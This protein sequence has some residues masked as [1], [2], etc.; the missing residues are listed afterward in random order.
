MSPSDPGIVEPFELQSLAFVLVNLLVALLFWTSLATLISQV[1]RSAAIGFIGTF[2]LLMVQA[3]I[4]PLLPAD[5]GS[6]TFGYGAASLHVSDLAPD[7][8]DVR[9]MAYFLS[10]PFLAFAL[11]FADATLHVRSDPAKR[12][13]YLP[14]A[15][16]LISVCIVCQAVVHTMSV[17]AISQHRTWIQ[18]FDE[19]ARSVQ[20][21]ALVSAIEGGVEIKPGSSLGLDLKYTVKLLDDDSESASAETSPLVFGFNPGMKIEQIRCSGIEIDHTHRRGILELDLELCEPNSNHEYS[22]ELIAS[23]KPVPHYLVGHIPRSGRSDVDPQMLRLMGQ[24]SSIFTAD[25]VALTA[26]SHWYPRPLVSPS[27]SQDRATFHP[28]D[29]SLTIE[30]S[31]DSWTLVTTGGSVFHAEESSDDK[32]ELNGKFHSM[33]LLAADFRIDTHSVES[34]EVNMLVH[35]RHAKRL[36]RKVV[37]TEG[38]VRRVSDA[39]S[40]LQSYGIDYPREQFSVVE[41]PN[42]LSQLNTEN[43]LNVGMESIMVFRES[44][45]PFA[46]TTWM[47]RRYE[48]VVSNESESNF[49]EQQLGY[50]IRFFWTNPT[51]NQTYEDAI[52]GTLL[53][54]RVDW[55]NEHSLLAGLLLETLLLDLLDGSEFRFDFDLANSIASA[56]RVNLPYIWAQRRGQRGMDLRDFETVYLDSNAYWESI[57]PFFVTSIAGESE[58]NT[59]DLRLAT[60]AQKFR[61]LKFGELLDHFFEVETVAGMLSN[62]MQTPAVEPVDLD[63]LIDVARSSDMEIEPIVQ[64]TL[65]NNELTGINFSVAQQVESEIPNEHGHRFKTVLDLRNSEDTVGYVTFLIQE[66]RE[67]AVDNRTLRSGT[68]SSRVGPFELEAKSSYRL[69]V[70]TKDLLWPLRANTYLSLNRGIVNISVA[71]API[72]QEQVDSE[73]SPSGWYSFEPS[74]WNAE[75]NENE[76]IVDDLDA[77]FEIPPSN[78]R[79]KLLQLVDR[80]GFVPHPLC[81]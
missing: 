50:S 2:V 13:M 73:D 7:Y 16:V 45:L 6:F 44:G 26:L 57:E 62:I 22:F 36:D 5:L 43:E 58:N 69:T 68:N 67:I 11:I 33:G 70:N 17:I 32:F 31:P 48:R 20:Y 81:S 21:P 63:Q 47:D 38:L 52:V 18:A 78:Y 8:W 53:A 49:D 61:V 37:L 28:K 19:R 10:V 35:K 41:I 15:A 54:D 56:S 27:D 4:A 77:G 55:K 14:I 9:H 34:T 74:S 80:K 24:R 39:L 71:K 79:E 65:L 12:T 29:F 1:L 51:F 3:N 75:V 76:I 42:T 40:T 25:Y 30:L 72:S 66:I 46:S 64:N 23:G 60:R 59:N